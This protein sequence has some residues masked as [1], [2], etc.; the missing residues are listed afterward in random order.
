MIDRDTSSR[1]RV[2][3]WL[4]AGGIVVGVGA[5]VLVFSG[6]FGTDPRLVE[7][8]LIGTPLPALELDYLA[9]EGSLDFTE[10]RG[11]VVVINF[12]ASWCIPCRAEHPALT[13][14][15]RDYQDR[16]VRIVGIV[17][18][19]E[20][21]QATAFLDE[22]G[23][24]GDNYDYVVDPRSRA[25]VEL[26]VFGVPETYFVDAEGI[27]VGKIQGAVTSGAL[28]TVLDQILAGQRPSL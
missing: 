15:A 23:W 3:T 25:A 24:G 11:S 17:Y 20:I 9:E 2:R 8:P 1:S 12:W 13:A 19:D 5:L 27:I 16:G 26:G 28:R 7:S 6:R 22:L 21:P 18:Q 4:T 14:A 10:L